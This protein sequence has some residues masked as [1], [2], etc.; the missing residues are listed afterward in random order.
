MY[1][2]E[3]RNNRIDHKGIVVFFLLLWLTLCLLVSL[4]QSYLLATL[5]CFLCCLYYLRRLKKASP[6]NGRITL[7][8]NILT[9]ASD[10]MTCDGAVSGA[11]LLFDSWLALKLKRRHGK[12]YDWLCVSA[13]AMEAADFARLRRAV[14][15]A[16]AQAR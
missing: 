14:I 10:E 1:S 6:L 9:L 7:D 3:L 8:D 4:W 15:S 16:R 12:G 13:A 11:S 5:A 2:I